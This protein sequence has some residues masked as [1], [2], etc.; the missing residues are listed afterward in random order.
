MYRNGFSK[1]LAL[2]VLLCALSQSPVR[3]A[4]YVFQ[5]SQSAAGTNAFIVTTDV[6]N[7]AIPVFTYQVT[8]VGSSDVINGDAFDPSTNRLYFVDTTTSSN[9]ARL[10]YAQINAKGQVVGQTDLGTITPPVSF[11]PG[12]D[13]YN[14]RVWINQLSTN[15]VYGFDPNNLGSAPIVLTLPTPVGNSNTQFNL[16]DL[17][18]N[19]SAGRL[20][21]TG[22]L[23]ISTTNFF[24]EY[25]LNGIGT[26][27]LVASRIYTDSTSDPG[28]NGIIFDQGTG[29]LYGY[30]AETSHLYTYNTTTLTIA[31]DVGSN[32][33]LSQGGDLAGA[34]LSPRTIRYH[35]S[36]SRDVDI[37]D[38]L[39]D[40]ETDASGLKPGRRGVGRRGVRYYERWLRSPAPCSLRFLPSSEGGAVVR[41]R[42][43]LAGRGVHERSNSS[44]SRPRSLMRLL[45]AVIIASA[46][47]RF[48]AWSSST[49]SSTVS[50]A[51]SR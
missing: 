49:F 5:V 1:S 9:H 15:N 27:T 3:S 6:N 47:A 41:S 39:L 24:Y 12:A 28:P 37:T 36:V 19:D 40:W 21:I 31:S 51:M 26:P 14:G 46:R 23:G 34:F 8:G 50:R 32:S 13:F 35:Q 43:A 2:A 7:V 17:T 38:L 11:A 29:V 30:S 22:G 48:C 33:F 20:F 25:S 4:S 42:T 16:G 44:S 10:E 45:S 18:F